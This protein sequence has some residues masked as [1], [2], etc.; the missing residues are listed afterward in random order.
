MWVKTRGILLAAVLSAFLSISTLTI[1]RLM[2]SPATGEYSSLMIGY[3]ACGLQTVAYPG[4][5]LALL[6]LQTLGAPGHDVLTAKAAIAL[7][8]VFNTVVIWAVIFT[9]R[10]VKNAGQKIR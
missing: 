3:L 2:Y 7:T 4:V 5:Q 10:F 9:W 8:F 6:F 1:D